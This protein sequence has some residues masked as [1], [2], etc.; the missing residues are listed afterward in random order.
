MN[1]G[2]TNFKSTQHHYVKHHNPKIQY[3]KMDTEQ[4]KT[5]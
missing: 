5:V 1:V 3:N 4:G 2:V